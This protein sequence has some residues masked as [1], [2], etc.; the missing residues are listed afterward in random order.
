M[1]KDVDQSALACRLRFSAIHFAT[2]TIS[3]IKQAPPNTR[4]A[5]PRKRSLLPTKLDLLRENHFSPHV[6]STSECLPAYG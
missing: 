4:K 3:K 1:I 2:N 6:A 5:I